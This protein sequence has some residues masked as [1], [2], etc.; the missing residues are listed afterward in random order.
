M[1]H[2]NLNNHQSNNPAGMQTDFHN[3]REEHSSGYDRER[4]KED[5]KLQSSQPQPNHWMRQSKNGG[6][7]IDD[8]PIPTAAGD[9]PKTFEEL[10]AEKM[11]A[12]EALSAQAQ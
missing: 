7:D 11:E 9:G 3:Y 1:T 4:D 12:A 5:D 8:M 2:G 6:L 10:L